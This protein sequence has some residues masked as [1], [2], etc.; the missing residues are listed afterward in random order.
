[1]GTERRAVRANSASSVVALLIV[2]ALLGCV[3]DAPMLPSESARAM[4]PLPVET[5]REIGEREAE[6]LADRVGIVGDSRLVE[7]VRAIGLRLAVHA[8]ALDGEAHYTFDL[9]DVP[10][11]S[12]FSLPGGRVYVS[13]G[14]VAH[15]N[16]ED[17]LASAIAHVMGHAAAGHVTPHRLVAHALPDLITLPDVGAGFVTPRVGRLVAG[18]APL[19]GDW[20]LA[21]YEEVQEREADW[22]GQ[23]L[24]ARAGWDPRA[25]ASWLHTLQ[26]EDLAHDRARG[27]A[28]FLVAHPGALR[29]ATAAAERVSELAPLAATPIARGSDAFLEHLEGMR[30][31]PN[32]AHG[33]DVRGRFVHVE[34]GVSVTFPRDWEL[35][36]GRR[37]AVA[38]H[39][40]GGA[41]IVFEAVARGSDPV[42]VARTLVRYRG[43]ELARAPEPLTLGRLSTAHAV[44][45]E[46]G[47]V[48]SLYW[49]A[50]AGRVVQLTGIAPATTYERFRSAFEEV[51][52]STAPMSARERS[53]IR[54]SRLRLWQALDGERLSQ[55]IR[56]ISRKT[57][58]LEQIAIANALEPESRLDSEQILKIAVRE[59]YRR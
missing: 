13:R 14:L 45:R 53:S 30:T 40:D 58:S 20:S 19:R 59:P 15:A 26:R 29:R 43:R 3:A 6:V 5:E 49:V 48:R 41:A 44:E 52:R 31:G 12:A 21:P 39:P 10:E 37:H 28:R 18:V 33:A 51:A 56:R 36:I 38:R 24:T 11:P 17:E 50:V 7:Y 1:M 23:E 25:L 57:W 32:P 35:R 46:R 27:R 8:P 55:A 47:A 22:I 54:D 9:L 42:A 4:A 2:A 16:S 34:L